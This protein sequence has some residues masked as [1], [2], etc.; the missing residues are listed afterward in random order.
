MRI[1][2]PT[3]KRV[4]PLGDPSDTSATMRI[5]SPYGDRAGG[6]H[7]GI[8]IG[9]YVAGDTLVACAD[10]TVI[11]V[12]YLGLPWS[13]LKPSDAWWNGQPLNAATGQR[14][15]LYG[16]PSKW[17]GP[18]WGGLQTIL[19][20]GSGWIAGYAHADAVSV[21]VGQRVALG[22][23]IGTVGDTGSAYRQ[24]HLHFGLRFDGALANGH[25][26]WVNPEPLINSGA[27]PHA[28][29]DDVIIPGK[30]LRH[31][32]N[33]RGVLTTGSHFR[34]GGGTDD[35]LGI[36]PAGTVLYPVWVIEARV[37]GTA[38]D[39]GEWYGAALYV[40]SKYQAGFVHSSVLPRSP[41]GAGVALEP[42]EATDGIS[43]VDHREAVAAAALTGFTAGR[44]KAISA[45]TTGGTQAAQAV[46]P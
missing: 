42:I 32:Q 9:N 41:D 44:S 19:G 3:A 26:G 15:G 14:G 21:K 11:A 1:D 22:Q 28:Q 20:L 43:D 35:S 24:P 8:D 7:G 12:G 30:F 10:A 33:R 13:S 39:R 4:L 5:T 34:A 46:T 37:V 31:V 29:E 17:D 23:S 27:H 36:L 40:E 45:Y 2:R 18:M 6:F 25:G 38:P 16:P